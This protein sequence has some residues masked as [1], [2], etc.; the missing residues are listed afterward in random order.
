MCGT[1]IR[2]SSAALIAALAIVTLPTVASAQEL[3]TNPEL[4]PAADGA[5]PEGWTWGEWDTGSIARYAATAGRD[6]SAAAG[7]EAP[8]DQDRGSWYQR[9]PLEGRQRLHLSVC[10]RTEG[11][12]AGNAATVRLTWLDADREFLRNDRV[13]LDAAEEWTTVERVVGAPAGAGIL[14]LELFNFFRPGVV[15][16]D[17]AHLREATRAELLAFDDT[18][19]R[20][21]EWGFRPSGGEAC[22]VTPPAFVWRPQQGAVGYA[23][24]VARDEVFTDLAWEAAD[25]SL[26]HI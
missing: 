16:W 8:T 13:E 26:I 18:P 11:I 22:A 17:G 9:V 6:G 12:A 20:V 15:W 3:L 14:Q 4:L 7:I 2:P 10:Y 23:V 1:P 24:Q 25:L 19:G 21:G 5:A